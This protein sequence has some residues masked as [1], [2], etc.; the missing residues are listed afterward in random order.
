V[1]LNIEQR[2]LIQAKPSGHALVKDPDILL[3]EL[4]EFRLI[5]SRNENV[6]AY[7]IF[8]N[9][10]MEDLIAKYPTTKEELIEVYGFG[11]KKVEKYGEDILK[12]FMQ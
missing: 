5:T 12:I 6:K 2:K 10:Q 1:N 7:F 3:K 8:D 9:K 11:P 4:K